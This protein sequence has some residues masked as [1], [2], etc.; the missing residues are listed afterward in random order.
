MSGL[1][2]RV[3]QL[4]VTC[5][6][7]ADA[8]DPVAPILILSPGQW[9]AEEEAAYWAASEAGDWETQAAVIERATGQRPAEPGDQRQIR[10]VIA[11]RPDGPQ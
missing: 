2:R 8:A 6:A 1:G 5:R 3:R 4:E 7:R 10:I 9:P 11:E